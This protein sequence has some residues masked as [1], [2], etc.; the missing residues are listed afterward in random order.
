MQRRLESKAG[1]SVRSLIAA[2]GIATAM[3]ERTDCWAVGSPPGPDVRPVRA[4]G[5]VGR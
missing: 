3:S 4:S 1:L 2:L 5:S